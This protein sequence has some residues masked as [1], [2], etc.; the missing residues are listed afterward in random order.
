M[1]APLRIDNNKNRIVGD[2][3]EIYCR[4]PQE[5]ELDADSAEAAAPAPWV[6]LVRQ[7]GDDARWVLSFFRRTAPS[8]PEKPPDPNSDDGAAELTADPQEQDETSA[9]DDAAATEDSL[10][11]D[12]DRQE[13]QMQHQ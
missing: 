5:V 13:A 6:D 11:V 2:D 4:Q 8:G 3:W 1:T 9:E 12:A 7:I 10:L